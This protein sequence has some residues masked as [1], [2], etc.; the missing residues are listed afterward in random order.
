MFLHFRQR[1]TKH[2]TAT[3]DPNATFSSRPSPLTQRAHR[4]ITERAT[5][6]ARSQ[7]NSHRI[8][9]ASSPDRVTH[10][11]ANPSSFSPLSLKPSSS[12]LSPVHSC[13]PPYR[14]PASRSP[15]LA[16]HHPPPSPS[17]RSHRSRRS[18]S[19]PVVVVALRAYTEPLAATSSSSSSSAPFSSPP[20]SPSPSS[21]LRP[22]C[23]PL[24]R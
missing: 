21:G 18:S 19:S 22:P 3:S 14:S 8:Q 16:S 15:S 20:L 17:H 11:P 4:S 23:S 7:F 12:T 2:T 13:P 5:F 1:L 9:T 6:N 24:P 10:T